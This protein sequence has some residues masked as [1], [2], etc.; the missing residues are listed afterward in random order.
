MK[1]CCMI[2][3]SKKKQTRSYYYWNPRTSLINLINSRKET[4]KK[5]EPVHLRKNKFLKSELSL[6]SLH[7][8]DNQKT[9]MKSV[10][11]LGCGWACLTI[12]NNIKD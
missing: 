4:K 3:V 5:N 6:V 9:P 10:R 11:N 12:P 8:S 1:I 2:C 7:P